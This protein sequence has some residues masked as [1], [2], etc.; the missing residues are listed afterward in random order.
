M[1]LL[2][3]LLSSSSSSHHLSS[4]IS[5]FSGCISPDGNGSIEPITNDFI[6]AI[7]EKHVHKPVKETAEEISVYLL[8]HFPWDLP[9]N[10]KSQILS[11]QRAGL[12]ILY[13][14]VVTAIM[15]KE[16]LSQIP[17]VVAYLS[18]FSA[19]EDKTGK[20]RE[21]SGWACTS[22]DSLRSF[23][24]MWDFTTPYARTIQ[25]SQISAEDFF[26]ILRQS[27]YVLK[28][29]EL[30]RALPNIFRVYDLK[31]IA[32]FAFKQ[33]A[34]YY[35]PYDKGKKQFTSPAKPRTWVELAQDWANS[36]QDTGLPEKLN[37]LMK[38][39]FLNMLRT[40]IVSHRNCEQHL[41]DFKIASST[42]PKL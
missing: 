34:L 8:K 20:I 24:L 10:T 4:S 11:D 16:T 32:R 29:D 2:S 27:V 42:N 33:I 6:I 25:G 15:R 37:K 39:V 12:M 31:K 18:R 9:L 5:C 28:A 13:R 7:A 30:N 35:H 1:S 14:R 19:S 38:P 40:N 36:H 17:E 41:K 26:T 22:L 21:L 3:S 23:P